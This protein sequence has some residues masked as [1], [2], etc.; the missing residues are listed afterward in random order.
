MYWMLLPSLNSLV[1]GCSFFEIVEHLLLKS[2]TSC[3][4][5]VTSGIAK[6]FAPKKEALVHWLF[7]K[8]A[9]KFGTLSFELVSNF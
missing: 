4:F 3:F 8:T 1:R 2:T 9:T 5:G 7:F 6:N